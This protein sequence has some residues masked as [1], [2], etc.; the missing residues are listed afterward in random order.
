MNKNEN[1]TRQKNQFE[2]GKNGKRNFNLDNDSDSTLVDTI[3]DNP[4]EPVNDEPSLPDADPPVP[5]TPDG[6]DGGGDD[7][8]NNG[9]KRNIWKYL[10]VLIVVLGGAFVA[11]WAIR[12]CGN[13]KHAEK[14]IQEQEQA[15][16]T[17][18]VEDSL[19]DSIVGDATSLAAKP[20]NTSE[21]K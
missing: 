17:N 12:G 16:D 9:R 4:N 15:Y 11:L 18:P 3:N 10:I 19:A 1:A 20:L 2:A 7:G 14:Y 8:D 6:G 13:E 5:E 21:E